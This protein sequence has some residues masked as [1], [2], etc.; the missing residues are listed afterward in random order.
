MHQPRS[1]VFANVCNDFLQ[2]IETIDEISAVERF[3]TNA[4]KGFGEGRSIAK[5]NLRRM[6]ADIPFVVL[7][8]IE[9]GQLLQ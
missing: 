9:Y 6:C 7:Y 5:A 1:A 4:R 3:Y 8:K 2:G